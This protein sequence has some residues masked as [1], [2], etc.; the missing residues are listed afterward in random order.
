MVVTPCR[1]MGLFS[2]LAKRGESIAFPLS[3]GDS[4]SHSGSVF[5]VESPESFS[6]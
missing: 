3:V 5:T 1:Q 4:Q 6:V 2:I